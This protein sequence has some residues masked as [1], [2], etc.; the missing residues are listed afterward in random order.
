[1]QRERFGE[2][3]VG[4]D[5]KPI[6]V[7]VLSQQF[8]RLVQVSDFHF[9]I[10]FPKFF[11]ITV[12]FRHIA[13]PIEITF[14]VFVP[15][16][17]FQPG[18]IR[19]HKIFVLRNVLFLHQ[20]DLFIQTPRH[21][22]GREVGY[23]HIIIHGLLFRRR[24]DHGVQHGLLIRRFGIDAPPHVIL[25]KPVMRNC[26]PRGHD[27]RVS[28]DQPFRLYALFHFQQVGISVQVIEILQKREVERFL[29]VAVALALGKLRG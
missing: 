22:V 26:R 10:L 8:R 21:L 14:V 15:Q 24:D 9:V 13:R 6:L 16:K 5:F 3:S 17:H 2:F 19:V 7:F 20:R 12:G 27:L 4:N 11:D 1:V 25:G 18:G 28:A 29:H 23:V